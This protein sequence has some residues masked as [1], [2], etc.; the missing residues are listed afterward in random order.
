MFNKAIV[1][2]DLSPASEGVL[3]CLKGVMSLGTRKIVLVHAMGIR[4]LETIGAAW[5]SLWSRIF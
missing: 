4:H 5:F 3:E 2:T 1:A